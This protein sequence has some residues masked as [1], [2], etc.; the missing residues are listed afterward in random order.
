MCFAAD[1]C[2]LPEGCVANIISLTTPPDACRL[3][4]VSNMFRS[5][6]D[7][8]A[9]WERF[10]PRDYHEVIDAT[11]A[12]QLLGLPKKQMFLRLSDIPL[13]IHGGLKSFFLDKWSGKKCFMI[14]ARDLGIVWGDTPCY[15]KW[16][17]LPESRF[18]EVAELRY[19]CWLEI[20]GQI[21]SSLLSAE[22]NYAVYLVFKFTEGG[23]YGFDCQPA[24]AS[25][26]ISGGGSCT[27][28]VYLDY[29]EVGVPRQLHIVPRCVALFS[30]TRAQ[31]L[32]RQAPAPTREHASPA[33]KQRRDGWLEIELGEY[34][35]KGGEVGELEMR[36][37]EVKGGNWKAGLV[38]Q[39]MEVRPKSLQVN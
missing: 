11:A 37:S 21:E 7:S 1:F 24:E 12:C 4:L 34:F 3:A 18:A 38:V 36:L 17:P 20:R 39:G 2:F 13:L 6:A 25:V 16:M 8:D 9:V 29:A 22:T 31:L 33:P 5:A 32:A 14:S 15:W 23:Y 35:I 26:G 30:R 10:L 19:V 28:S 27:K